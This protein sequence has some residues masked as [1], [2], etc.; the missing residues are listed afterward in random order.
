MYSVQRIVIS[1]RASCLLEQS[2]FLQYGSSHFVLYCMVYES[3]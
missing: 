1:G 3:S 2:A